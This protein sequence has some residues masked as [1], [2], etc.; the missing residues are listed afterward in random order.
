[1]HRY[2]QIEYRAGA[3][4]EIIKCIPRAVRKDWKG[5]RNKKTPEEIREANVRQAARKLSRILNA[6]FR[7]GDWHVTLTYRRGSCPSPKEGKKNLDSFLRNLRD[8][9]K[10]RGFQLKYVT[11]TEYKNK[12]IHHHVILN[13]IND[14]KKTTADHVREL[15]KGRGNP[16]FIPL[17]DN[18]EYSHLASYLIKETAKTFK[19]KDS[20]E[21]Q[22]YS[23]S[24]NLI[25]PKPQT[26][27]RTTKT[28]WVLDPRPRPGY[29]IDQDTLY[30]GFDRLGYPYQRY[31]LVKLDPK[32]TDW[33]PS[34]WP[35]SG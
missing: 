28:G 27:I 26:R 20:V 5:Q 21:K 7:P 25:I 10:R 11:V 13:N 14:G 8:R 2:K 1:M 4:V 16:K 29:Y 35:G 30:N 31:I 6:N 15:W 23:S 22:R 17:Y 32:E 24:R 3:T 34:T 12:A 9:Y 33:L 18:G 19:E